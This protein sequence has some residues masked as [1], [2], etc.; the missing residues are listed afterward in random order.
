[1]TVKKGLVIL[2]GLDTNSSYR[3]VYTCSIKVFEKTDG[4]Y[5]EVI[6]QILDNKLELFDV[7]TDSKVDESH[8]SDNGIFKVYPNTSLEDF[9][10]SFGFPNLT[11]D[12]T[13]PLTV[14]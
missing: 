2:N 6:A 9:Y 3:M 11:T 10:A 12:Y 14:I 4:N 5:K 8:T 7:N 13:E 1:M